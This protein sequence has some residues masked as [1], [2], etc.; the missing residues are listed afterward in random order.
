MTTSER[1]FK[2]ISETQEELRRL[3][4]MYPEGDIPIG[5][6][7][8]QTNSWLPKEV[9]KLFAF[10]EVRKNYEPHQSNSENFFDEFIEM[11]E[12][13]EKILNEIRRIQNLFKIHD[14]WHECYIAN[15]S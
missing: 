9:E 7:S 4:A 3:I 2:Q 14:L 11:K 5:V 15:N 6:L 8:F 13:N 1:D 10:T 12:Q